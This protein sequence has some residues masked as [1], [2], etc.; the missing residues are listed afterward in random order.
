MRS[1]NYRLSLLILFLASLTAIG[2]SSSEKPAK[3]KR[4]FTNEDLGKIREKYGS[5]ANPAPTGE[6]SKANL[7]AE[8]DD[9]RGKE[10]GTHSACPLCF[11]G[12]KNSEEFSFNLSCRIESQSG[13]SL[14]Q[15]LVGQL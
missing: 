8:A 14:H 2:Q 15:L 3:A 6:E 13:C 7:D 12:E 5:D 9:D 1:S 11:F 10:E 4:V